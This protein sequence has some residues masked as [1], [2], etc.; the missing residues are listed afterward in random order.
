MNQVAS[1]SVPNE[2]SQILMAHFTKKQNKKNL[3]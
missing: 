2:I 1:E 3:K